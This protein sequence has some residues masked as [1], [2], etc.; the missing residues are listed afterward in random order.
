MQIEHTPQGLV[1]SWAP[2]EVARAFQSK[3]IVLI[4][5]RTPQEF[6]LEH[7]EGALLMPLASF[8]P[9]KLPSQSAKRLVLHCRSGSRSRD[10]ARLALRAGLRQ[11]AHLG[12]GLE[13]WKEAGLPYVQL[14]RSTGLRRHIP[15]EANATSGGGAAEGCPRARA[16]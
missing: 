5:V 9:A 1:E 14:H 12:G 2:H 4:D 10:A 11:V 3:Q 15:L 8:V 6:S 7:I 13:A 16:S